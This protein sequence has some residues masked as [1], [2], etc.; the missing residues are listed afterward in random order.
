MPAVL[1]TVMSV[2]T[3][4]SVERLAEWLDSSPGQVKKEL[5]LMGPVLV[6]ALARR[7]AG[8]G[9]SASLTTLLDALPSKAAEDPEVVWDKLL[10]TKLGERTVHR[11]LGRE[12]RSVTNSLARSTKA[13]ELFSLLTMAAPLGLA[14]VAKMVKDK[15]LS[16]A[17]LAKEL[18]READALAKSRDE[19]AKH[20]IQAF[21]DADE[22]K[23]L[24]TT[25][26]KKGWAWLSS[27]PLLAAAYVVATRKPRFFSDPAG[28]PDEIDT[29]AEAFDPVRVRAGNALV[30]GVVN[31]IRDSLA[32]VGVDGLPWDLGDTDLDDPAR[33]RARVIDRLSLAREVLAELPDDEH[34]GYK[35]L[36]VEAA[37]E[38]AEAKHEGGFMGVGG[39]KVS[40]AE[41]AAIDDIKRALYG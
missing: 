12:A 21:E 11:L 19:N 38:V 16:A 22:Q 24:K 2:F 32:N 18:Q 3:P 27:A 25:A 37:M 26:H 35:R 34:D 14:Q 4:K 8:R 40:E 30:D 5:G 28:A 31:S 17:T 9:G 6:I 15:E 10:T 1:D 29:L 41:Q 20:V 33:V 13:T 36:I 39:R 23:R 7:A